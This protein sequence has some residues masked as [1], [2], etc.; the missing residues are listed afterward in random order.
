MHMDGSR[1]EEVGFEPTWELPPNTLSKRAHSAGLCDSS[2]D[3][4]LRP[5]AYMERVLPAQYG[6]RK[7]RFWSFPVGVRGKSSWKSHDR[8][9]L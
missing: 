1:A 4:I 8:G 3:Q 9:F 2:G 6:S 5:D 7:S